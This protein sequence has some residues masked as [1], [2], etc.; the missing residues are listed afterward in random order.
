[1]SDVDAFI[2]GG[3]AVLGGLFSLPVASRRFVV[4]GALRTHMRDVVGR[5]AIAAVGNRLAHELAEACLQLRQLDMVVRAARAGNRGLH[6]GEIELYDVGIVELPRLRHAEHALRLVVSPDRGHD[7]AAPGHFQ[8]LAGR[9]VHREETAGRAVLGRHVADGG[10]VGNRQRRRAVS[11]ELDELADHLL[12]PQQPDDGKHE[13]GRGDPFGEPAR[14][15]HADHVWLEEIHRLAEHGGF[16]LDAAH[17]PAQHA[18]PVDHGRV[19]IDADEAVE[20]EH[21]VLTPHELRHVFEVHL[22][23]DTVAGRNDVEGLERLRT[24][25]QELVALAVALEFDL[26]VLLECVG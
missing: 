25:L 3:E 1:M 6:G 8:E 10:A 19:R 12:F 5:L 17:A 16:R 24:P 9:I 13:I 21:L 15:V 7:I 23:A 18:E 4:L 14:Q 26:H 11:E 22:V 2:A 20:I